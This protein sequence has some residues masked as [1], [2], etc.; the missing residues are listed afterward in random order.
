MTSFLDTVNRILFKLISY[1]KRTLMEAG[2]KA[3]AVP[4]RDKQKA[5]FILSIGISIR[6]GRASSGFVSA[7]NNTLKSS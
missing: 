5:V 1:N 2:A 6:G 4:I 7:K 3:A